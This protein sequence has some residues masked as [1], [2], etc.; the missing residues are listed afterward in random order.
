MNILSDFPG[1]ELSAERERSDMYGTPSLIIVQT[2]KSQKGQKE[3]EAKS[4]LQNTQGRL[5]G[6][7]G[8]FVAGKVHC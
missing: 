3:R 4:L 7:L 6:N 8:T 2:T 1:Q 5:A